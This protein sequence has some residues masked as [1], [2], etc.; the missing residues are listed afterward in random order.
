MIIKEEIKK[1]IPIENLDNLYFVLDFDRTI[2]TSDSET[3]WSM[4]SLY[5][6]IP[7]EYLK[8]TKILSNYYRQIELSEDIDNLYKYKMMEEWFV[9]HFK[10]LIKYK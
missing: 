6:D 2:T 8:E 3:S 7:S 5:K 4:I 10:I 9:K 1:R